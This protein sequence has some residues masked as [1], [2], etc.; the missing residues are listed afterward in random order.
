MMQ[1]EKFGQSYNLISLLTRECSVI[2]YTSDQTL[3]MP[4]ILSDCRFP[5]RLKYGPPWRVLHF[6]DGLWDRYTSLSLA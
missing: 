4:L 1:L 3:V 5:V 2:I 6:A